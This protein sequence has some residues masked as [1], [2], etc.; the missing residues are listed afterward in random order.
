MLDAILADSETFGGLPPERLHALAAHC[1]E[2]PVTEGRLVFAHGE[3]ADAVYLVVEGTVTVFRDKVGRAMQLL[4]RIGPG[5]LLGELCL[6]DETTRTASARAATDCRLLRVAR[7]PLVEVLRAEPQLAVRIQNTAARRRSLNSAAALEL[8]Q[9]SEVRIRLRAP[10]R[11]RL[12]D[13][14]VVAAQLANLSVGGLSLEGVPDD[15]AA[16]TTVRFALLVD[17]EE[18][19]VDGRIAWRHDHAVGIAVQT[20]AVG[21]ERVVYRLLRRLAESG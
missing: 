11:V 17:G 20:Q 6:F 10:V 18:L 2:V 3:A 14:R 16:G 8:G 9:Q 7:E 1:A 19:H 5:E 15:W 13:G 12:A 4:A 21:H